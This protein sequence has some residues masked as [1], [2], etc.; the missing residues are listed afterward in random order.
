MQKLAGL[1]VITEALR[2]RRRDLH[3]LYVASPPRGSARPM[4]ELARTAGV[5][6]VEIGSKDLEKRYPQGMAGRTQGVVLEAG[7]LPELGLAEILSRAGG[8]CR[9]VALDGVED[10]QNLGAV[11]RAAEGAG[12]EVLLLPKHRSAPL[13]PAASR[14]SAGAL[15]HL[16]VCRVPNLA[17]ALAA[18]QADAFW[19]LGADAAGGE[20]LFEAPDRVFEGDVVVVLGAE[21]R[22]IRPGVA[23]HLDYRVRIPMEGRVASLNVGSS[24]AVVLFELLRRRSRL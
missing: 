18:L 16:L 14:A 6:V 22:G 4:M 3:R 13:S 15:E 19:T 10:P 7:P 12:V 17:K 20:D 8:A 11:A 23:R 9:V 1:H 2:A 24:A 5:E 21:G